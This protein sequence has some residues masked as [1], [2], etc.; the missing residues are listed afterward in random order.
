MF[1][2]PDSKGDGDIAGTYGTGLYIAMCM[3]TNKGS[4][5]EL[6]MHL[7]LAYKV[8]TSYVVLATSECV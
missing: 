7:P 1:T 6:E 2:V 3:V 8:R 4:R 5:R